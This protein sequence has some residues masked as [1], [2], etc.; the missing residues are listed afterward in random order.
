M[1][2]GTYYPQ[3]RSLIIQA[4]VTDAT[5]AEQLSTVGPV[6]GPLADLTEAAR[7]GTEPTLVELARIIDPGRTP[8]GVATPPRLYAAHRDYM[9]A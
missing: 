9:Q 3:G 5:T 2:T 6:E 1:V 7:L 4:T 8:P